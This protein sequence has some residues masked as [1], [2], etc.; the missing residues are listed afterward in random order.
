VMWPVL[1]QFLFVG[2]WFWGNLLSPQKG[3]PTLNGTLLTPR[4]D[5][6][7]AGLF[8]QTVQA[9]GQYHALTATLAQGIGSLA[10]LLGCAVVVQLVAWR[11]LVWRE[12]HR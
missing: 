6:I 2:Y 7:L 9:E 5:F 12:A 3:I 1:Y 4:G 11:G 8:P 10:A